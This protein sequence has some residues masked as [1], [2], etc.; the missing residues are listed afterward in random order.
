MRPVYNVFTLAC[1]ALVAM[2]LFVKAEWR[3]DIGVFR[4]GVVTDAQPPA[5]R[6]RAEPFRRALQDT[7][8]MD[9]EFF[10]SKR[11]ESI[12][13][14]LSSDR[15]EYAI[16]SATGYALAWS[17]CECIEPVSSPR[18]ADGTDGYNLVLLSQPNG[19]KDLSDL[20]G[21]NI[22]LLSSE[23]SL[24][25]I[26]FK[27]ALKDAGVKYD[28]VSF[29]S[30]ASGESALT[31]FIDGQ[32]DALLGWSSFTG[33]PSTGYT[34]GIL[35]MIAR[36]TDELATRYPVVWKS[37]QLPHRVHL[38]RKKLQ[39]EP[40]NLLRNCLLYTSPSPRDKRQSRMPSS[41]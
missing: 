27:T 11:P 25:T 26:I 34:R 15:I 12:I 7:L 32:H 28:E 33:N 18:S 22:A 14:A 31:A 17:V 5:F 35:Q 8:N 41:A 24:E 16:L 40:K 9:V 30:A 29:S 10:I 4:I 36:R 21:K 19:P 13:D 3:S 39:G 23:E 2:T 1:F 20:N 37:D 6:Q 38:V